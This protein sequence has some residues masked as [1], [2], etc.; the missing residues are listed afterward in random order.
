MQ[1]G[2]GKALAVASQQQLFGPPHRFSPR[3]VQGSFPHRCLNREG[4]KRQRRIG[5]IFLTQ[6]VSECSAAR[7]PNARTNALTR[8]WTD[9]RACMLPVTPFCSPTN[10][11][12]LL[13]K[14]RG[15]KCDMLTS[16]TFN[17]PG[18]RAV[19]FACALGALSLYV[20]WTRGCAF[21]DSLMTVASWQ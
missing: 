19:L 12:L 18:K 10:C 5:Y 14:A 15:S 7:V 16:L 13:G 4:L 9:H 1:E 20:W 2:A 21:P 11:F 6:R 8:D 17:F 3:S